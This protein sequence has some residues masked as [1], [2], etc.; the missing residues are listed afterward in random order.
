MKW[1]KLEDDFINVAQ[2]CFIDRRYSK[3]YRSENLEGGLVNRPIIRMVLPNGENVTY[4]FDNEKMRDEMYNLI[5]DV[6]SKNDEIVQ[7]EEF[8]Y[9]NK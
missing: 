4:K 5:C 3:E 1:L 9:K 7:L 2:I 8:K 6:I